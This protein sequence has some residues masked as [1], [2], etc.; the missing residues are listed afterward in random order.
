MPDPSSTSSSERGRIWRDGPWAALL[1]G[2]LV[3]A[4]DRTVLGDVDLWRAVE[5]RLE[6]LQKR[7]VRV[8]VG[9]A[10]DRVE[11]ARLDQA[12]PGVKRVIAMGNGG[13]PPGLQSDS[14]P[15]SLC[16]AGVRHAPISPLEL[17]LFA[18]EAL[19]HRVDL[20]VMMLSEYD[21][22][23]PVRIVPR[24]G[25]ADLRATGGIVL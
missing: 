4:A 15:D 5:Q 25:F 12:A 8:E 3:F 23:R 13:A 24:A 10:H 9:I 16:L 20:L 7:L 6:G 2:L 18:R 14:L 1:A 21:T 11:L 22:H 17:R 19:S